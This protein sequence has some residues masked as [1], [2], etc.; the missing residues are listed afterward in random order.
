MAISLQEALEEIRELVYSPGF[1]RAHA[2]GVTIRPVMLKAGR[3]FQVV[4][5]D[6]LDTKNVTSVDDVLAPAAWTVETTSGTVRMQLTKKGAILH[7]SSSSASPELEHDR[8]KEHLLDPGD[9][10]F[11]VVGGNAA[12]RRQVDAFLRQLPRL[13]GKVRIVDLGCGNAYLTF[14]A[15][16]YLSRLGIDV[17]L[18]GV[19]VREDQRIRNTEIARRLGWPIQFVAGEIATVE[20]EPP[21]MVLA[22]H[23]CD[24]ATDDALA[25]A[26]QWRAK[27]ILAAPCCH[28]DVS[29]QLRSKPSKLLTAHGI[30]RER[31]AD[32]LTDVVRAGLLREHG[33]D[34]EVVEFIDSAHT[35]RNA[36]IKAV[37]TGRGHHDPS[38]TKLLDEWDIKPAMVEAVSARSVSGAS[39]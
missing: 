22:L 33:Y 35:P 27:W 11:D 30:L 1:V 3:R 17:E 25:R 8:S 38:L 14:A 5:R 12:K 10:L 39:G 34:V 21:D 4:T 24:T 15:Y 13:S 31:F 32:V 29:R 36:L 28:K 16:A 7:R 37:Y 20:L 23:A 26:V 18:V 6:G 9:A 2:K 19:D